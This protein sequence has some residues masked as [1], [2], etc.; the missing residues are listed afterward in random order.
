[1]ADAAGIDVPGA[2]LAMQRLEEAERQG[3]GDD[4]HPAVLKLID[5]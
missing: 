2:R 1:L 5:R 3:Y 4:Y